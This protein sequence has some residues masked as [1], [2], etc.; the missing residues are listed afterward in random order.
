MEDVAMSK[1]PIRRCLRALLRLPKVGLFAA[2][3]LALTLSAELAI[4]GPVSSHGHITNV[5]FEGDTVM[6]M[7]DSGPPDN[8]VNTAWGWL[9]IPAA[10]KAMASFVLGLWLRGDASSTLVTIYSDGLVD[11]YCRVTQIDPVG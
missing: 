6:V 3:A 2:F 7:L 4:A 5:T 10:S 9:K 8:C 11:G 1:S